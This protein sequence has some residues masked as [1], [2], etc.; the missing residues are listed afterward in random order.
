M[1]PLK[2]SIVDVLGLPYDGGTLNHRGLGGSE[3]AI[4]HMS[5]ELVALGF[6]VT[7]FCDCDTDHNKPGVYEGV[8]FLPVREAEN[9]PEAYDIMIASRSVAPFAPGDILGR[10]KSFAGLPNTERMANAAGYRVLWMHDT[11]CDG[12][13]L[14]E[15]FCLSGRID[16]IFTLS[17]WHTTYIT[18]C[19]H[20]K[21]RNYEV[22]KE[23]VWQTRNGIVKY[24]PW[25]DIRAKDSNLFVFNSSVTKGMEPLVKNI[26]PEVKRHIPGAKLKILGGYY[27]FSEASGPDEQQRTFF[28]LKKIAQDRPDLDIEFTGI[29]TQQQVAVIMQE[30]SYM[31]YPALFPETFGISVLEALAYNTPVITNTFGALESIALDNCSYKIPYA[32]GPNGLFPNINAQ[33]QQAKFVKQTVDAFS[34]PYLH[35]QKQY[36]C[37]QVQDICTWYTVALQWKQHFYSEFE[38]FLPRKDY[39]E[40]TDINNR[41]RQVYGITHSDPGLLTLRQSSQNHIHVVITLYNAADYVERCLHSVFSQDYDNY[42]VTIIDD[43]STDNSKD[44]IIETISNLKPEAEVKFITRETNRGAVYNQVMTIRDMADTDIVMIVDGDDWLMADNQIFHYIN[45]LYNQ[46]A[47]FTYGSCWSLVDNIPLVAQPYPPEIRA[48][49]RYRDYLFNWNMP[50]THLR[51]FHAGLLNSAPDTEFQD[52]NQQWYRAGGDTSVFYTAIEAADPTRV[53]CVPDILYIYN[54]TNPINDYKV[55]GKEQTSTATRV[56]N[57][58]HV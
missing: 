52:A 20:G 48:E 34:N 29:V 43:A 13:D 21:R 32:I 37:N 47:E 4:I 40:V 56:L 2:I 12:D 24:F 1:R 39:H 23:Y 22:L 25:T 57:K 18:N 16:R 14:I 8:K 31:L 55:N 28:D 5:R 27:E 50:Y 35:Q 30:A 36:A 51:T 45:N 10:F 7:V 53:L 9:P 42:T 41:V 19:Q 15:D 33:D 49:R 3:S 6:E 17:D 11:F 44:I 54:D 26:W 46:G 38:Y 58:K